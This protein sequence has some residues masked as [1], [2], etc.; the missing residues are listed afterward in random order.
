MIPGRRVHSPSCASRCSTAI[1]QMSVATTQVSA[2]SRAP[3]RRS[4]KASPPSATRKVSEIAVW[5]SQVIR[6]VFWAIVTGGAGCAT[7]PLVG[8]HKD[9]HP[10]G[11]DV[12]S[13]RQVDP[14]PGQ[15]DAEAGQA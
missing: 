14:E 10:E 15:E 2:R 7:G 9:I 1:T 4:C 13:R 3:G 5:T 6:K 12:R 8:Y 11:S